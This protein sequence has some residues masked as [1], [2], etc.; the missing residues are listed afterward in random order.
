[1]AVPLS[2]LKWS[3][4][5]IRTAS[6]TANGRASTQTTP[7]AAG[8]APAAPVGAPPA[9]TAATNSNGNAQTNPTYPDH[10]VLAMTKD[11]LQNAPSYNYSDSSSNPN[12]PNSNAN[13]TN[14]K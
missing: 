8:T 11:D 1:V 10:A 6:A 2:E 9:G 12:N 3:D 14:N 4:Q 13:T 7:N 5:P